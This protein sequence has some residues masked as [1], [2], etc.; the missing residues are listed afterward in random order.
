MQDVAGRRNQDALPAFVGYLDDHI[1]KFKGAPPGVAKALQCKAAG[2]LPAFF[3]HQHSRVMQRL[4]TLR[5]VFN[6]KL[7]E[8][9][10]GQER[11][12]R[13]HSGL[14]LPIAT[15]VNWRLVDFGQTIQNCRRH[16]V[17]A[18]L[19]N[20]LPGSADGASFR[21]SNGSFYKVP[22]RAL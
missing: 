3:C 13:C 12:L 7:S 17:K 14:R 20:K 22:R 1:A 4:I 19:L 2:M 5:P 10:A 11:A 8:E 18:V 6:V 21:R 15:G 16:F 9:Y